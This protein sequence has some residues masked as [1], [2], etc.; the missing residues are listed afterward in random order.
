MNV[1]LIAVKPEH[2]SYGLFSIAPLGL[3]YLGTILKQKG[4]QVS[5]YD[6]ARTNIFNRKK[7]KP[8]KKLLKS[9]FIG[10]SVIS[11]AA[12]RAIDMLKS[13]R[14]LNPNI[15]TA[16]GGPHVLGMKQAK[17]FVRHADVVIQKEAE[18]HIEQI[19]NGELKGIV[20]GTFVKNLDKLPLPDLQLLQNTK[21]KMLD[22]FKL[23]PISSSRGCPR[24]CEFCAVSNIHGKRIRYRSAE[25][26]MQEL[27]RRLKEGYKRIFFVDDNFSVQP[28][29]RIPL[30]EAMKAENEKG[31]W[32]ESIIIQD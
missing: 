18:N 8:D 13:I 27:K 23:T 19:I 32:F 15:R 4:H 1:A 26:V 6:E 28:S 31:S 20:E 7:K 21:K 2:S 3:V 24:N 16:V 10:L 25:S 11:P 22:F 5:I 29:R 14:Q 30:L 12:N 17:E 9:D